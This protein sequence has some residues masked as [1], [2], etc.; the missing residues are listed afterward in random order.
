M[1][2]EEVKIEEMRVQLQEQHIRDFLDGL[3]SPT[4][5]MA[6]R[7]GLISVI[8]KA[9]TRLIEIEYSFV[10][11]TLDK[12]KDTGEFCPSC[13]ISNS[14]DVAKLKQVANSFNYYLG[15]FDEDDE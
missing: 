11:G 13:L 7:S 3:D 4:D 15:E 6:E 14:E 5:N 9:M 12:L 10:E 1:N 2:A 8:S